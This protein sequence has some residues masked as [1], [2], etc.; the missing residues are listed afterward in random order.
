MI[1][2]GGTTVRTIKVGT[3]TPSKIKV[4]STQVWP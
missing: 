1:K 4:G 3:L 2:I